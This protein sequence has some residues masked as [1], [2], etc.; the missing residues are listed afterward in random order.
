MKNVAFIP[1]RGGSKSI[2]LKNIKLL[3]EKPMVYWTMRAACGC[4]YVDEVYIAT[5]SEKINITIQ[6][7]IREEPLD[8]AKIVIIGRSQ[9]NASDTASTESALLEFANEHDF[10]N[11]VLIQATSPLLRSK[12]L[13]CGF[14]AMKMPETDSVMSVVLQKRLNWKYDEDK[15]I[16]PL[17]YDYYHRPRRQDFE[18]YLTENGAFYI[19]SRQRLLES[20]CRISG[21]IR[22]VEM[23]EESFYEIDEPADFELVAALLQRQINRERNL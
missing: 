14:E 1:V 2:P 16:Y 5:D 17:N 13:D 7:L 21:H 6:N 12:D 4:K 18:G 11:V 20:E 3:N 15:F 22:A 23:C 9:E 8:L 10:D 19:T